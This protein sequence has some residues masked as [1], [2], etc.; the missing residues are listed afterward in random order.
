MTTAGHYALA[1]LVLGIVALAGVFAFATHPFG[2]F[3]GIPRFPSGGDAQVA[4]T[5]EAKL[6]PDGVTYVG[7]TGPDCHF[8]A[9]PGESSSTP[10]SGTATISAAINQPASALGVTVTP[11][12]VVQD[13]RCAS[14]VQCVWAGTVEVR[15]RVADGVNTIEDTFTLGK[16]ATVA[17]GEVITLTAVAPSKTAGTAIAPDHYA[18]TFSLQKGAH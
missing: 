16:A 13:S 10:V 12:E 5:M 11:L 8:A 1:A 9:C 3:L 14:G 6:C 4:C 2:S 7:R 15:A 18:F 17:Y